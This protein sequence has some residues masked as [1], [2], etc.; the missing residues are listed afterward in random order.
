MNY[1][2]PLWNNPKHRAKILWRRNFGAWHGQTRKMVPTSQ[3]ALW[4]FFETV[5]SM[6]ISTIKQNKTKQKNSAINPSRKPSFV[7]LLGTIEFVDRRICREISLGNRQCKGIQNTRR[8]VSGPCPK[9]SKDGM[10]ISNCKAAQICN[11]LRHW[12]SFISENPKHSAFQNKLLN[13]HNKSRPLV[14]KWSFKKKNLSRTFLPKP[15]QQNSYSISH[16]QGTVT[17]QWLNCDSEFIIVNCQQY[18]WSPV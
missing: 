1:L 8:R 4:F 10:W 17:T 16:L 11:F 2:F 7:H 6:A 3:G 13:L 18:P 9:S 5:K 12:P 14:W 15:T